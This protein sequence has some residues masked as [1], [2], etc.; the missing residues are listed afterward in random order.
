M[1]AATQPG[2]TAIAPPPGVPTTDL[3]PYAVDMILAPYR[4]QAA[5]RD[6]GPV[7][8]LDR[9][10]T[11]AVARHES[12]RDVLTDTDHF[13]SGGG[14]GLSDVRKPGSWRPQSPIAEVDPP[15]HTAVRRT[16][17]RIVSPRM[18]RGW[19]DHFATVAA[20]M[21]DRIAAAGA[22]EAV[23][24]LIEPY[25]LTAFSDALGVELHFD[26]LIVIGNHSFNASG[27]RNALFEASAAKAAAIS[28]WFEHNQRAE[29][30]RPGGFGAQVFAAEAAGEL[31]AGSASPMLR[32]L[33]RG[34]MDTT[35]SALGTCLRIMAEE[36]HWWAEARADPTLA[37]GIFEEAIRLESPVQSV[38]RTTACDTPFHDHLLPGDTKVQVMLGAA[39][40]DPRVWPD[41]D[42]FDPRRKGV[43]HAAFGIG[44]HVCL[45]QMI[46]RIEAE[47]L[48]TALVERFDGIALDGAPAYRPI[49][50][51]RTLDRLPLRLV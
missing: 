47:S 32:T 46:A 51:L 9:Y 30:M 36:P 7:V 22:F 33:I 11:F 19:R 29:A 34:G 28:D 4:L 24:A 20:T 18:V 6:L 3:D 14:V 23:T 35:I 38:Y 16:M 10:G 50:V 21:C 25:V 48:L 42:R 2:A 44:A 41:P 45:G 26:N 37:L 1:E 5:L 8:W 39:N 43:T 40:R 27:P 15:G 12:V 13:L 31:P 17:N 49:N